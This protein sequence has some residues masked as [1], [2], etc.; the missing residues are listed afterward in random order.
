[1]LTPHTR[2]IEILRGRYDPSTDTGYMG[3]I[4]ASDFITGS[5]L[6]DLLD[7]RDGMD[8]YSDAGWLKFYVGPRAVCNQSDQEKVLLIAKKS[9]KCDVSWDKI[10]ENQLV[11]GKRT[12]AINGHSYRVRLMTG[13]DA[14]PGV[15]SEWNE[16]M[17]RVH[18]DQPELKSNWA[19]FDPLVDTNITGGDGR[20]VWC[21]ETPLPKPAKHVV[22]VYRGYGGLT[23]WATGASSYSNTRNGW[24]P[25]LE[26]VE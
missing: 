7:F 15:G 24:R 1:M 2:T 8:Q 11:S 14:H 20:F 10:N 12:L 25:V 22:R 5:E 23:N 18:A 26:L 13:G 6:I 21:Q 3:Y 19:T 16:L 17:Y 4:P 9:L